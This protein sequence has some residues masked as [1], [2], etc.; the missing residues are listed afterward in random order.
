[1]ILL[2]ATALALLGGCDKQSAPAPQPK[3]DTAL[4]ERPTAP[5]ASGTLDI[6][7][8]GETMPIAAFEAPN[9][10]QVT[11]G[12]FRG[13]PVLVNIWA[14]WCGP[15]KAELAS[16]DALAVR[17]AEK[18]Q[19]LVVSQDKDHKT[20]ADYLATRGFK[21][22]EPYLDAKFALGESFATGMV[23]TTVLYDK[24]GKEIWR[25]VGAMNWDGARA[26][27]LMAEAL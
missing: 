26:N 18:M 15:C 22:L 6:S 17:Q 19:V 2:P 16:L 3:A 20:A 21:R 7:H 10:D 11:L 13:R 27:T 25:V 23:P 24:D 1:M 9:G 14:T 8:R 12:D 5:E 4:T